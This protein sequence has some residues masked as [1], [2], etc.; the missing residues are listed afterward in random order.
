MRRIDG[1]LRASADPF[2]RAVADWLDADETLAPPERTRRLVEDAMSTGDARVY[3]LAFRTC[4]LH[5]DAPAG[6]P[7]DALSARRWAEIDAGNALPWV[8]VF[9]QARQAGDLSAQ[10]EAMTRMAAAD[11]FEDRAFAP[12]GV[13]AERVPD[14]DDALAAGVDLSVRAMGMSAA[15]MAPISELTRACRQQAGGDPNL[16]QQCRAVAERMFDRSDTVL[17]RAV[18]GALYAQATGD[19]SRREL[20]HEEQVA[21]ASHWSPSTG[22]S[23][24]GSTRDLLRKL[25]REAKV[26]ELQAIRERLGEPIPP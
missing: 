20:A 15:E 3:A 26:G 13:V 25:R 17:L 12:A 7:C 6:G 14:E 16:A 4:Q 9:A 22:V 23:E 1:A 18:G 19:P 24:C 5:S 11:R 2:D 10:Q 8:Y 21:I